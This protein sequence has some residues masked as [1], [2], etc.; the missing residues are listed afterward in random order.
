MA[1]MPRIDLK[2]RRLTL[3]AA[4]TLALA[5]VLATGCDSQA[6]RDRAELQVS[7]E[8]ATAV[9]VAPATKP[10][11]VA[12]RRVPASAARPAARLAI[13][14][15]P[16][17]IDATVAPIA[18]PSPGLMAETPA[19][20]IGHIAVPALELAPEAPVELA[21]VVPEHVASAPGA[22]PVTGQGPSDLAYIPQISDSARVAYIAQVDAAAPGQ[23]MAV[24]A[25]D[26]VLG[27]VEFQVANGEVSVRIG[28]VLDLFEGRMDGAEF[29]Q[30]QASSAA[31]EFVSLDRL[32]AAGIPL[33]YN[34]AYDE[35]TLDTGR[36]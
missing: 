30:L 14:T 28:Q 15:G 35:L 12:A 33:D 13:S 8:L 2:D 3:R 34:A 9:V 21:A 31:L 6:S 36:S 29:A 24:R 18:L 11:V 1:R 27:Q 10:P 4:S 32:Q 16:V 17:P 23:R 7:Y 19:T 5:G 25:G 20:P 22:E 26:Q